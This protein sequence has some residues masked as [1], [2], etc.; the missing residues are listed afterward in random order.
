[1]QENKKDEIKA[2]LGD[3]IREITQESKGKN[4]YVCP[5]CGSGTGI[6]GTGAFTYYPENQTYNCF[7]CSEN[8]DIFT[9][10]AK[11]NS[12]DC[13]SD[14]PRI[15]DELSAKYG[16]GTESHG[17]SSQA[18]PVERQHVYKNPDGSI[19]GKK[20]ILKY[21]NGNKRVH[22]SLFDAQTGSYLS[23]G[24]AGQKAPLYNADL[25]QTST[26]S[27]LYIV[28]GEKDA[29]T[30]T[31]HG[32]L[33]TTIPN[34]AGF[35]TWLDMYNDGLQNRDIIIIT[36][37]DEQG[38]KYGETV[39]RNAV[40]I[41]K[42]VRVV[43]SECV[44]T[45]CPKKGDI[46]DIIGLVG[47]EK[48][49]SMLQS[50]I[51]N[52]VFYN[53]SE[54]RKSSFTPIRLTDIEHEKCEFL[55]NP[56]I[57]IGEITVMFAAGGT[58]K[59]F[60]TVGIAADITAGRSLPRYNE[61][62]TTVK[63]EKVL[64][65]SA[66]DSAGIIKSRMEKTNGN[67]DNCFIIAENNSFILPQSEDDEERIE[68]FSQLLS[69]VQPKLVVIDPWSV[70]LGYEKNM[71]RA[72]EVRA[73]TSVLTKLAKKFKCAMLIVAH[74]NKMP[75]M[76]NANN[77][78][79]GSTALIDSARSALCIRSLGADSDRRVIVHTKA[80]YSEKG[81]S[82]CYRIIN[83]GVGETARFQWDGFCDLTEDDPCGHCRGKKR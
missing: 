46:S 24:L 60:A 23:G 68:K 7:S 26:D 16:V 71:N 52:S 83:E 41:A 32:F 81:K 75:Q 80:N 19:F 48:A 65:I 62:Q 28:E 63:P 74:V 54:K 30:L 77:A 36:D 34:G 51:D 47:E 17:T 67:T 78:V 40:R 79:S 66:E 13:N 6:H 20:V 70:Y 21:P 69:E 76:E 72:N 39:A 29:D 27:T 10:Y 49:Y 50:A 59:S 57:P 12:L 33:A 5:F 43:P 37:N 4:Q 1:M 22:W 61:E 82:V 55:W 3:Y 2:Y 56:Y 25:L 73:V 14:F 42:T 64:F 9:L 8:G 38:R 53:P 31:K 58:G 35:S 15:V 18:S 11:L 44:Y 45:A